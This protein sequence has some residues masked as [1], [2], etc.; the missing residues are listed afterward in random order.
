MDA[1]YRQQLRHLQDDP[2]Q[3][4]VRLRMML[5]SGT[6]TRNELTYLGLGSDA[7]RTLCNELGIEIPEWMSYTLELDHTSFVAMSL[8][9]IENLT[10]AL[11]RPKPDVIP[12]LKTWLR[13]GTFDIEKV[14]ESLYRLD[15]QSSQERQN[16][17][18]R[19]TIHRSTTSHEIY[20][21]V[22]GECLQR[23]D[24]L[25][26]LVTQVPQEGPWVPEWLGG[27]G[28]EIQ[29]P[30]KSVMIEPRLTFDKLEDLYYCQERNFEPICAY[31]E[32]KE[33]SFADI[34]R[35]TDIEIAQE[36][37]AARRLFHTMGEGLL[38][39]RCA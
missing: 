9:A 11:G 14:K 18:F 8:A 39:L 5:R 37:V 24:S 30:N 1:N 34:D 33:Y 20:C 36:K 35:L 10:D 25:F 3:E 22:W 17:P 7:A 15:L 13:G 23:L 6:L 2:R 26:E 27:P 28:R 38:S 21:R 19:E 12:A 29:D 4:I 31:D 32:S 16:F